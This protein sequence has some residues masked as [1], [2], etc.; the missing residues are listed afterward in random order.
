MNEIM[1]VVSRFCQWRIS[2]KP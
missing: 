1:F 2:E